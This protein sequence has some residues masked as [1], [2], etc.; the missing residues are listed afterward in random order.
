MHGAVYDVHPYLLLNYNG[1]YDDVST[2]VHEW[3]HAMHTVLAKRHNPYETASYA[4]FTA[5]IASITNEVLLQEHLLAQDLA[6]RDRLFYLGTALEAIRGT[7]FRQAMFAEFELADPRAGGARRGALGREA[8][9][10]VRGAGAALPRLRK[11][12][13]LAFDPTYAVEWAF[14]PH[15][16]TNFYVFQYA[17]SIAGGTMFAARFLDGDEDA[18]RDYLAVLEAGGS[19]YACELLRE[20]GIDLAD[21]RAVRRPHR[22]HGPRDGRDRGDPRPLGQ[23]SRE[24]TRRLFPHRSST[25][26]Y[27]ELSRSSRMPST[28]SCA[29]AAT[30]TGDDRSRSHSSTRRRRSSSPASRHWTEAAMEGDDFD[31][32]ALYCDPPE[33]GEVHINIV[34]GKYRRDLRGRA[35]FPENGIARMIDAVGAL[36]D[37]ARPVTLNPRLDQRVEEVRSFV[38]EGA[39]PR[40]TTVAA[41]NGTARTEEFSAAD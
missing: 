16:Y 34:Q 25:S 11:D 28:T 39:I 9:H 13:V 29:W 21:R 20:H 40:V 37:P 18:R 32:D 41:F 3:G 31:V 10:P 4:T 24:G 30:C 14:V 38:K 2:F 23:G 27:P 33:D 19:R 7:F 6:D 36:F 8:E 26:A 1:A 15:F 22:P 17:T 5:E 12:G 35:A